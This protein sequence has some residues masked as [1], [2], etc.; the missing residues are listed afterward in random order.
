MPVAARWRMAAARR[1]HSIKYAIKDLVPADGN[2]P[3]VGATP[4]SVPELRCASAERQDCPGVCGPPLTGPGVQ[5]GGRRRECVGA[6]RLFDNKG[7]GHCQGGRGG[8]GSEEVATS[9]PG[10][11]A[12][13]KRRR[14]WAIEYKARQ[15]GSP[16]HLICSSRRSAMAAGGSEGAGWA[17]RSSGQFHGKKSPWRKCPIGPHLMTLIF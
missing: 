5:V 4:G 11:L 2:A 6:E 15:A 16:S 12:R 13:A 7:V 17:E 8:D 1:G 14:R 10:L 3:L 9:G